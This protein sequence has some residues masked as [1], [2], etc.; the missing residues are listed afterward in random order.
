MYKFLLLITQ[1][2]LPESMQLKMDNESI[3]S[4]GLTYL[5]N[6]CNA[7][8]MTRTHALKWWPY[9][10]RSPVAGAAN[11]SSLSDRKNLVMYPTVFSAPSPPFDM[12]V[13][14]LCNYPRSVPANPFAK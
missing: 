11:F 5:R 7:M 13:R 4:V 6:I 3:D 10:L 14:C 2:V 12:W 8:Q 1:F 9:A